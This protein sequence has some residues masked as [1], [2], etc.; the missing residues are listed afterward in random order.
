MQAPY[1]KRWTKSRA[2]QNA[3]VSSGANVYMAALN[4]VPNP[5]VDSV[6]ALQNFQ[7]QAIRAP[8]DEFGDGGGNGDGLA[9]D[10]GADDALVAGDNNDYGF[11]DGQIAN[12]ETGAIVGELIVVQTVVRK[13]KGRTCKV[14]LE[15]G[16]KCPFPETCRGCFDHTLCVLLKDDTMT[17]KKRKYKRR[18]APRCGNCRREEC[19]IGIRK[20]L[21]CPNPAVCHNCGQEDCTYG[22]QDIAKCRNL[23]A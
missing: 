11:E 13:R 17:K 6:T 22:I 21:K 16:T 23:L 8:M 10:V 15:N 2:A 18:R 5:G 7:L 12:H 14:Q 4:H 9:D 20:R 3:E 1:F 19:T